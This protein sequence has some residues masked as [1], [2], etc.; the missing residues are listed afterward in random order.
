[1]FDCAGVWDG[2]CRIVGVY[3]CLGMMGCVGV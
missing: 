1:M 2:V 3:G